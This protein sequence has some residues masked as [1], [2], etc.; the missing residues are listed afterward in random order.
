MPKKKESYRLQFLRELIR[1][2]GRTYKEIA[3]MSDGRVTQIPYYL[4][5]DSCKLSQALNICEALGY[6]M[7]ME[8]VDEKGLYRANDKARQREGRRLDFMRNA[9]AR[10]GVTQ[11][12]LSEKMGLH[13]NTLIYNFQTDDMPVT[14]VYEIADTLGLGLRIDIRQV[15]SSAEEDGGGSGC[16]VVTTVTKTLEQR[17]DTN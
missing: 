4:N 16:H 15:P 14:R 13:P 12:D 9:L 8:L 3:D 2:S 6:E 17:I 10:I 5:Q 7:T 11:K 1:I